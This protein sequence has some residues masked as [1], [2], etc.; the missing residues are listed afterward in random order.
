MRDRTEVVTGCFEDLT[1]NGYSFKMATELA[2]IMQWTA[3]I[4]FSKIGI[5]DPSDE[6]F[7]EVIACLSATLQKGKEHA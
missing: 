5:E 3:E 6:H 1:Q 4:L 2:I 7:S